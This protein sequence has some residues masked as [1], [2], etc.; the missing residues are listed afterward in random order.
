MANSQSEPVWV[1]TSTEGGSPHTA[2][3]AIFKTKM[4]ALQCIKRLEQKELQPHDGG[5]LG[6]I[7]LDIGDVSQYDDHSN[8]E[9]NSG[10]FSDDFKL[11]KYQPVTFNFDSDNNKVFNNRGGP[12]NSDGHRFIGKLP[13]KLI[14]N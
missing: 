12:R 9:W 14:I 8:E 4:D 5:G 1:F 11:Y 7:Y 6:D 2:M 10:R 13:K 3:I